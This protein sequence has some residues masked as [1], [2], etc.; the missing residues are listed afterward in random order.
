MDKYSLFSFS[1]KGFIGF[2]KY[3]SV[4]DVDS[5]DFMDN[6][7]EEIN[8]SIL[9]EIVD[10]I[11]REDRNNLRGEKKRAWSP[12]RT[13]AP[14]YFRARGKSKI[15]SFLDAL[16]LAKKI[17]D[18][19]G[20][21]WKESNR[22][23]PSLY[24]PE[25]L[26]NV[27]LVKHFSPLSFDDI[28]TKLKEI[29]FDCRKTGKKK[30]GNPVPSKSEL[31]WAMLK[32]PEE[33]FQEANRLLEDWTVERHK[34][35]FG[36]DGLNKF[37]V[38]GTE[39][40]CIELEEMIYAGKLILKR[41]TDRINALTRLVTNTVCE[42]SSSKSE[43][44]KDLRK[45]LIQRKESKRTIKNLEIYGDKDYDAE[46]NYEI[47]FKNDTKLIVKPK[48][49]Q[50]KKY[51]GFYRKKAQTH[52]S[53]K[54]YKIRKTVERPFANMQLRDGNKIWYKRPDMKQKG[55]LLRFIGHNMKA[56]FMQE[57]WFKVFKNLSKKEK[58]S[59]EI[60]MK[61]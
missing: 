17:V 11:L 33:Y 9:N 3:P 21:P 58:S 16:K 27:L 32:I 37:G 22:G 60:K 26:A 23:R 14:F 43:N 38:D 12:K 61:I 34:K 8:S 28:R 39:I 40:E 25:K 48:E 53:S 44:T 55:E 46:Y 20:P 10:E 13:R 49:F 42:V 6:L 45:L 29:R 7:L 31:H 41:T 56:Y 15:N 52:F 35:L 36:I 47:T 54:K 5:P 18:Q 30:K 2:L 57:A 59:Q 24:C 1:N 50:G 51:R 4:L 19:L